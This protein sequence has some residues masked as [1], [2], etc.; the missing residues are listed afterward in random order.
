MRGIFNQDWVNRMP[1][2]SDLDPPDNEKQTQKNIDEW[3]EHYDV[4][5]CI[6]EHAQIIAEL[7]DGVP[8]AV[9]GVMIVDKIEKWRMDYAKE[10]AGVL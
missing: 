5:S 10:K 3:Y 1:S 8:P 9:F 4:Q 6:E 7:M 2:I